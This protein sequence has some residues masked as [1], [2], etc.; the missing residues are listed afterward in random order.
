MNLILKHILLNYIFRFLILI[1]F[2]ILQKFALFM[3]LSF[4]EIKF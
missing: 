4:F 3:I 1:I 2:F